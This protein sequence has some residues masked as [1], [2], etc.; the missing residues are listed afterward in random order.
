MNH[1]INFL[2]D[3]EG[4]TAI[5]YTLIAVLVSVVA[6]TAWTAIGSNITSR[7]NQISSSIG[8]AS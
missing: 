8:T 2:K 1:I 4:V 7:N 5:E 3:E 6:I